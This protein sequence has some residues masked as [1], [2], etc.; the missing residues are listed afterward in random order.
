MTIKSVF[1]FTKQSVS[2][3]R[4]TDKRQ[5]FY[6]T[7]NPQL[8]LTVQPSGTKSFFVRTTINGTTKRI[9]LK[10]GRFP[11]VTPD[12]A[13]IGAAKILADVAGGVNTIEV[14][15]RQKKADITL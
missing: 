13:R 9:G 4:P 12:L 3:I 1:N 11:G 8:G 10:P 5:Y 15:K 2:K 14:R 7:K 6:D